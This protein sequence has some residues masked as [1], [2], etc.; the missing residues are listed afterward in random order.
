MEID[1]T[2]RKGPTPLTFD[3]D[4][5][6]PTEDGD[7]RPPELII[8]K[9][10]KKPKES[11]ENSC[12]AEV[13]RKSDRELSET[14]ARMKNT[15]KLCGKLSDGGEKFRANL[16]RHEDELERR[17]ERQLM[18]KVDNECK[19]MIQVSDSD[20]GVSRG[21]KQGDQ[22]SLSSPSFTKL[23]INK[24]DKTEDSKD[25]RTVNAFKENMFYMKSC[26]GRRG[27]PKNQVAGKG[28]SRM[29]V[30]S[31]SQEPSRSSKFCLVDSEKQMISNDDKSTSLFSVPNSPQ[32]PPSSNL[33]PRTRRYYN[34][35]DEDPPV[36]TAAQFLEELDPCVK[37][38]TLYYPSRDDPDA[39][40]VNHADMACLA[41]EAY[42]SSTI[43]NFYIRYLQQPTSLSE[44]TTS[45]Y[46]FFSTY[47]YNKL[48]KLK[49][50][51]DSFRKF[52]KWWKDVSI[53]EKAY[54][55][56]PVHE[57]AH[58]SLVIICFPTKE[59]EQGPILLHY[60]SL[61]LH[62]SKSIF[63]NIKRFLKEE[64]SYLRK[65]GTP[66]DLPISDEIWE[67]LESK[68]EKKRV[69]VP[70]QKNEYDC[71][72]FVLFYMER[73][74]KEAPERIKKKDL[75]MFGRQWFLPQ[76]A[77][78]LRSAICKLLLEEFR[79]VKEKESTPSSQVI[80]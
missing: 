59:D 45:N 75:S 54:I 33:R 68:V 11:F 78:N 4:K 7:D 37:D 46:H 72:L 20:D 6:N 12:Q 63:N 15:I 31:S 49:Y 60:D 18:Q 35:V 32:G 58:W 8:T 22:K 65:S 2:K 3:W 77:S 76:E 39:V 30:S 34:V 25:S 71:G 28:R 27:K 44:S 29:A 23:L 52:R 50:E 5:I 43:M 19:E 48:E 10:N 67:N 62:N 64:W 51:E 42:L 26:N 69:T 14:I 9:S 40:D 24:L 38:V 66:L 36:Q 79:K 61:G 55:L 41:P 53:L 57:S 74:I 73:F 70:Q 17:R 13:M 80:D 16:K 47:F 56:L 21:K 1:G